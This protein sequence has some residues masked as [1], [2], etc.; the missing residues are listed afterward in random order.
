V[1]KTGGRGD[2]AVVPYANE[3]GASQAIP[4]ALTYQVDLEGG[5][6]H[7]ITLAIPFVSLTDREDWQKVA[8]LCYDD[9]MADVIAYWRGTIESGGQIEVP[10]AILVD[11]HKAV[12]THIAI[13]VDKDPASGLIVV[14]AA[15][16]SYGACGNEACWQIT[17]L[18]QAGHHDRAETYLETFLRTQG[19]MGLDGKF[20]LA[21]GAL[22]GLELDDGVP[23]RGGFGYNLDHGFI[24]ECLANHYRLTGDPI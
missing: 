14:P 6:T 2:L 20:A 3:E 19:V 24:M 9:K 13:S 11:F 12:R 10:E 7:A 1:V 17:M 4:T 8:A 22:Q 21:E 23:V 16:W 5:E 18:D 15:T